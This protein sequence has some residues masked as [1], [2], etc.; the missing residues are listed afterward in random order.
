M[1]AVARPFFKLGNKIDGETTVKLARKVFMDE[2]VPGLVEVHKM[3]P[4]FWN[5]LDKAMHFVYETPPA[6]PAPSRYRY[7]TATQRG[8]TIQIPP[9]VVTLLGQVPALSGITVANE[10]QAPTTGF[11]ITQELMKSKATEADAT[12]VSKAHSLRVKGEK[13]GVELKAFLNAFTMPEQIP[14]SLP[15]LNYF[16]QRL[17]FRK[18]SRWESKPPMKTQKR[19][20]VV[21]APTDELRQLVMEAMMLHQALPKNEQ[22]Y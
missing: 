10:Y 19:P 17:D 18:R 16:M 7:H 15:Q 9:N 8:G 13:V 1:Q 22:E 5:R 4:D 12:V 20:R 6:P 21:V 11:V 14:Y 2:V 3:F